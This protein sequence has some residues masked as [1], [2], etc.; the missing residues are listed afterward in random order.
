MVERNESEDVPLVLIVDDDPVVRT[1]AGEVLATT[2]FATLEADSG[3]AALEEVNRSLPDLIVL[4]VEMPG[5]DGFETC[6]RLREQEHSREIPILI[7]TGHTNSATIERAFEAGATD[8]IEKPID[9][10]LLRHRLRFLLRARNAIYDLH[11]SRE[12]LASAQRLARIGNWE[13]VPGEGQMLWSEEVYHI[14]GI[15][16]RAGASTYEA[17]LEAAHPEDRAAI[18]KAM[19]GAEN[20][21][22]AVSLDHRIVSKSGAE[23]VIHHQAEVAC[24]PGGDPDRIYGTI[25]DITDRIRAQ[26]KIRY[27]AYYD[28]LTGLPNRRMLADH[29]GRVLE[30][31]RRREG[32]A[33]LLFLD[34][35]RFKRVNDTLGHAI[36]DELLREVA[37]RLLECV[38][39]TD[40]VSRGRRSGAKTVSRLGGDEFTAVLPELDDPSGAEHVA[41]R[42][43]ETLR[44]PFNLHGHDIVMSASIGITIFPMDGANTDTLISNADTAMYHA[45]EGGGGTYRFFSESMNER[46][47][48]NLRLEGGLRMALERDE[49]HL[50]YQPLIDVGTGGVMGVEALLR[51]DSGEFGQVSPAE[52]IPVAEECGLIDS[53]GEWV[54]NTACEQTRRWQRTAQPSLK[55]AVNVS[56]HQVRK[57]GLVEVV[58]RAL[59]S[60]GLD[61][62]QLE[63]EITE[64]ALLGNDGC[65]VE[66]INEL[67]QMGISLALDDFGTGY[68]SLSHLVHFPIDTLKIDQSFVREIGEDVQAGAVISAVMAMAH[69]LRLSVTAEGVETREQEEFLRAE[70]CDSFQGYR[71]SRPLSPGDLEAFIRGDNG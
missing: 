58:K 33:A 18:D 25:Q 14:F 47:M 40:Q 50:N 69:R 7:A 59:A 9:W 44:T 71:F 36:G 15:E 54:L 67:K 26:E 28:G 5:M 10:N 6:E 62:A 64:S 34:L 19:R 51:W 39:Q 61:P 23:R 31:T 35:D 32:M 49:I 20:E 45:K 46:A 53:L 38:R 63:L 21:G 12:R 3:A 1:I 42:I 22:E 24:G 56:S 48:R 66:T 2:G 70:G 11:S 13:W 41:R 30:A 55:V 60:S 52:F 65:V 27:L 68:S 4:D 43:L 8:F 57:P 37:R 29:L 16:Q 17:L